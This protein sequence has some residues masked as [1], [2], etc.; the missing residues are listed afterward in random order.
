MTRE[1]LLKAAI[2]EFK[3]KLHPVLAIP[4]KRVY[5][6]EG[7]CYLIL[8]RLKAKTIECAIHFNREYVVTEEIGRMHTSTIDF[9]TREKIDAPNT[10]FVYKNMAASYTNTPPKL[11]SRSD[12]TIEDS[13]LIFFA[14]SF[15]GYNETMKQFMYSAEALT[16]DKRGLLEPIHDVFGYTSF[17]ILSKLPNYNILPS[18]VFAEEKYKEGLI[19]L[20]IEESTPVSMVAFDKTD[21]KYKQCI[22]ESVSF[23]LVHISRLDTARF[24]DA[25]CNYSLSSQKFGIIG[26][27]PKVEEF[28]DLQESAALRGQAVKVSLQINYS[29]DMSDLDREEVKQIKEAVW[30]MSDELNH[31]IEYRVRLDANNDDK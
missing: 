7:Y 22:Q 24:I 14:K 2:T 12:F 8:D 16:S 26:S 13:D 30:K 23:N 28:A 15:D 5:T 21:K 9:S 3:D 27:Q 10:L 31:E 11:K 19:M 4:F 25:L 18:Y 17:D 6:D 20:N 1:F 29:M